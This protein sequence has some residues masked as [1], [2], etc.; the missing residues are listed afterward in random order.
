[1]AAD[2]GILPAKELAS[3]RRQQT[4]EQYRQEYECSFE[5]AILG[6]YFGKLL[7]DA[8]REGRI[9]SVPYDPVLPVDCAWDLG[10]DDETVIWFLQGLPGGELHCID[11]VHGTG[12]GVDYYL[13]ELARKKYRYGVD[14]VPHDMEARSFV[15]GNRSPADIARRHGRRLQ[16]IERMNPLERIQA[17]RLLIPRL[18]FDKK[19]CD[20]GIEALKQYRTKYNDKTSTFSEQ[21]LHDWTS[22]SAD[23]IGHYAV[24]YRGT[25]RRRG[26]IQVGEYLPEYL[27]E[28]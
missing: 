13:S 17:T 12:Q 5:A 3:A 9:T 23:A 15:A 11:F 2:T 16:I 18:W 1:M 8:E 22:H 28:P 7:E 21:P 25:T 24:A 19:R 26:E 10:V 27:G 6:A 20:Y 4:D 14:F